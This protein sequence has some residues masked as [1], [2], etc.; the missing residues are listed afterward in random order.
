MGVWNLEA[1]EAAFSE[2]AINPALWARALNVVTAQTESFGAI[3][4]PVAGNHLPNVPI[5]DRMEASFSAYL[6]GGW[7]L[8]DE[9]NNGA[10]I[11]KKNGVVDDLEIVNIEE[12]KKH[13][14]YQDFLAPVGLR[15]FAG[16]KVACGDDLWCLSVQ[17]SV[18]QTPF[19]S[20]EK[21]KLALLSKRLS[22]AAAISRALGFSTAN[23]AL[24][25][26][27]VSN[28][29]ILLIDRFG[30]VIRANQSAEDLLKGDVR[31]SRG[32][33]A[34]KDHNAA[35][36][37]ERAI[38]QLLETRDAALAAPIPLPR[39]GQLPILVYLIKLS[40]LSAN[41]LA[42]C[43]A[44]AVL[45]DPDKRWIPTETTLRASF[46]FTAAEARLAA[47]ISSGAALES[48]AESLGISKETGRNQ[49]KSIFAKTGVHRQAELVAV[50]GST[51]N[52]ARGK[53][54]TTI[55]G[56]ENLA[57]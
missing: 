49:L 57:R 47:R 56:V 44:V 4:V 14:Y 53:L 5:S 11:M 41:S 27:E 35:R 50:V 40:S 3:L 16:V 33:I 6:N 21:R 32:K 7:H 55:A 45:I 15:W 36:A 54:D 31:I 19:S 43:K 1:V 28:T 26:F 12:I 34:A 46:G 51:A 39:E 38:H 8:R 10:A 17:R 9:R 24:D 29:A 42:E 25:A 2:A 23:A 52:A 13:P 37:V 48:V 20:E 30:N 18:E 22:S